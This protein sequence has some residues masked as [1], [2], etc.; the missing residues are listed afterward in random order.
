MRETG[1]LGGEK[2][3]TAETGR[4]GK[5]KLMGDGRLQ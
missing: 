2:N 4:M 3:A 1:W 5:E